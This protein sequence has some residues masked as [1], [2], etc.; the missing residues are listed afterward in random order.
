[1]ELLAHRVAQ[2]LDQLLRLRVVIVADRGT[3]QLG[4]RGAEFDGSRR[5]LLCRAPKRGVL[6]R[7]ALDLADAAR[8]HATLHDLEDDVA[9]R[10]AAVTLARAIVV[11]AGE[12]FESARRILEPAHAADVVVEARVAVG[13]DVEARALL[14]ADV[15]SDR[16]RVLLAVTRVRERVTKRACAEVRGVPLGA[17]Q[18]AG[19]RG[20]QRETLRRLV[21]RLPLTT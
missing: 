20:R 13:D 4:R 14:V 3:D 21:H 10:G 16:V 2:V 5:E 11:S 7:T 1:S 19:D 6:Q 15:R 12:P 8:H 17:R 9:L 18:R